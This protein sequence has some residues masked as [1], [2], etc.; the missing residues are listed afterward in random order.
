MGGADPAG[1]A[2]RRRRRRN[3]TT[4]ANRIAAP[5]PRRQPRQ[6]PSPARLRPGHHV[7]VGS[8]RARAAR[9]PKRPLALRPAL[10]HPGHHA[11]RRAPPLA[12]PPRLLRQ[13]RR[14]VQLDQLGRRVPRVGGV[15]AEDT[16]APTHRR[17]SIHRRGGRACAAPAGDP[18]GVAAQRHGCGAHRAP[19]VAG[20]AARRGAAR[21]EGAVGG[22][23]AVAPRAVRRRC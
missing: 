1:I 21:V 3:A 12:P 15:A 16:L 4:I 23:A 19:G 18:L 13:R 17:A 22:A 5:Q 20:P 8:G 9:P 14:L 6:R 10:P 7:V 11:Q 2:H